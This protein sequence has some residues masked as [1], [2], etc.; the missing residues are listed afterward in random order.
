MTEAKSRSHFP[1][2]ILFIRTI[3][4]HEW[5]FEFPRVT[6]NVR[7]AF[8][9][10]MRLWDAGRL[11]KAERGYRKL[12]REYPEFID[13]HHHLAILLDE[14]DRQ[15][16]A[17]QLWQQAVDIGSGCFPQDF[18]MGQDTLPWSYITNRPFLRAYRRI[19]LVLLNRGEI[20][21]ALAIFM[22]MLALNPNDNQGVRVLAVE[23]AFRHNR[24]WDVLEISERFPNDIEPDV[25][26]GQVLALYQLGLKAEAETALLEA[27]EIL[28]LVAK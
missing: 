11:S 2:E 23:C 14:T 9:E 27:M 5:G 25:L 8:Y 16:E 13:L 17:F 6:P 1:E 12:L 7:E 15:Q 18:S 26:Y 10:S 28:P 19:G 24:P 3:G 21:D 4:E 22:N 20:E